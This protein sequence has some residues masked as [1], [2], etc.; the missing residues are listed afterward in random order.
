MHVWQVQEAKAKLTQLLN[1]AKKKPQIISRRGI[2]ETVVMSIEKYKELTGEKKD[3]VLFFKN[4]PL[5]G[6]DLKIKRDQSSIR[7]IDL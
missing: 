1:E 3:V 7:E 2:K 5:N 4:S 6:I